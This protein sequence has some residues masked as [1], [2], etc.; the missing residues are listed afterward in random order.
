MLMAVSTF[1]GSGERTAF[2]FV[3]LEGNKNQDQASFSSSFFKTTL[4]SLHNIQ[5]QENDLG[6]QKAFGKNNNKE[7]RN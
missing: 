4:L 2:F 6:R 5:R 1:R 7:I 3:S